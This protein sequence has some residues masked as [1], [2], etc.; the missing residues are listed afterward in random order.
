M[1]SRSASGAFWCLE[2]RVCCYFVTIERAILTRHAMLKTNS[3]KC[4][5]PFAE[6]EQDNMT[7]STSGTPIEDDNPSQQRRTRQRRDVTVATVAKAAGVS[8]AAV[9]FAYNSPDQLSTETRSRILRIA[10]ALGYAPDPV[11]RMLTTRRSGAIG[12]L[13]V[14]PIE[15]AFADQFMAIFVGGLGQMC[16]RHGLALT[17]LP[18]LL[19]SSLAMA[20]AAIVDGVVT[21]GVAP[22]LPAMGALEQRHIPLVLV[23]SAP[24][25]HWSSVQVDDEGGA[26]LAAD[27]LRELGHQRVAILS[28]ATHPLIGHGASYVPAQRLAGYRRGLGAITPIIIE[29]HSDATHGALATRQLLAETDPRPTAILA[30]SDALAIGALHAC[31]ELGIRVP[32]ELSIIGFDGIPV[33]SATNPPLT[34]IEQPIAEKAITAMQRLLHELDDEVPLRRDHTFLTTRLIVR[35]STAPPPID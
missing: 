32:D 7:L 9:S 23:D 4:F 26:F 6:R 1:A 27:H 10:D 31:H 14:E 30:M 18:P 20:Q 28:F 3:G 13:M 12:L 19:G 21:L 8:R 33:T 5:P 17:L 16:D 25:D 2:V 35:Q 15:T 11:A 34:T 22:D 24:N 29:T